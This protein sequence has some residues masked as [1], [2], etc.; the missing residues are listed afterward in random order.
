MA[1]NQHVNQRVSQLV[2]VQALGLTSCPI[3]RFIHRSHSS[4]WYYTPIACPPLLSHSFAR[5]SCF[6]C[7]SPSVLSF[8]SELGFPQ[9]LKWRSFCRPST[10]SPSPSLPCSL[11][12]PPFRLSQRVG[13]E[14]KWQEGGGCGG[15]DGG[16]KRH[17]GEKADRLT[18]KDSRRVLGGRVKEVTDEQTKPCRSQRSQV[19]ISYI[20]VLTDLYTCFSQRDCNIMY[21]IIYIIFFGHNALI[22][23]LWCLLTMNS[24]VQ[25]VFNKSYP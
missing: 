3:S 15:G 23:I 16:M 24:F 11:S 25:V 13:R 14:L 8:I 6:L 21:T 22:E 7:S 1:V 2:N 17:K 18:D 4:L 20:I 5:P 19:S 10:V 9:G 12:S